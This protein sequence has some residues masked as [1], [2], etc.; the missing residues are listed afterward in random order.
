MTNH[1]CC[2][3]FFIPLSRWREVLLCLLLF[4]Q[5]PRILGASVIQIESLG[6][7]LSD[8]LFS[9]NGRLVDKELFCK[10]FN[11]QCCQSPP[12]LG[13]KLLS[14]SKNL[15]KSV[16]SSPRNMVVAASGIMVLL[17]SCLCPCFWRRRREMEHHAMSKDNSMNGLSTSAVELDSYPLRIPPSP[18]R[19]SMSPPPSR[20]NSLHLNLNLI[21]KA[22]HHFSPSMKIGEGGFGD[23]Y[24]A[25]FPDGQIVAVKRAKKELF[26]A[27]KTEFTSE[28]ALLS[29]IEHRNLVK[30]LGYIDQGKERLL[31]MEYMP[32]GTL[33]EHLDGVRG[34]TLNFNQRMEISI[35]IAHGLTYLHLYSEKQI[36]HRD[37]KSSNILLTEGMRAKV[38]DF[39]FARSGETEFNTERTHVVT[40]VR[41][42]VGYIDLEYA[43]TNKLTPKSDVYSFGIL[44]L[45]IFTGRRP[46]EKKYPDNE[47]I[48][49]RWAFDNYQKGE[50]MQLVDPSMQ[51]TLEEDV[52]VKIFHLAFDCTAS[53]RSQ[54]PDMKVVGERLWAI[55][56]KCQSRVRG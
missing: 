31:V 13:R 40:Q 56:M 38:A 48:T 37:I 50:V 25:Q 29:K 23:V 42:T 51:E 39:G 4:T 33:R 7:S 8:G 32:N 9:I 36:I 14:E 55:R 22:T 46:F 53:T 3:S 19:F 28:I 49:I 16:L 45:E 11:S 18:S 21:I 44:L 27:L 6:C 52:L 17:C 30:L 1:C 34:K 12:S 47:R 24:K 10:T 20:V 54:R 26:E 35:D 15:D 5:L 2:I 41:G 43:K